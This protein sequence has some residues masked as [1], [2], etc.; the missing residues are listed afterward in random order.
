[1]YQRATMQKCHISARLFLQASVTRVTTDYT[2][3]ARSIFFLLRFEKKRVIDD[4]GNENSAHK[5]WYVLSFNS[6]D[7]IEV[8][9]HWYQ[10]INQKK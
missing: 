1:M 4:G 7:W 2:V 10:R 8:A 3:K 9:K 5:V 6:N